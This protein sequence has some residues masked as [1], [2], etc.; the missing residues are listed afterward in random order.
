M[1]G[2]TVPL[3]TE[4]ILEDH[5]T[6]SGVK[7]PSSAHLEFHPPRTTCGLLDHGKR[8]YHRG[9]DF[10]VVFTTT[11]ET[12]PVTGATPLPKFTTTQFHVDGLG[13]LNRC[14]VHPYPP[15]LPITPFPEIEFHKFNGS[16]PHLWFKRCETYFDVYQTDP[17]LWVHLAT[18]RLVDSAALW[19]QTMQDTI[20]KMN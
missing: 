11:L 4:S 15:Y 1:I 9:A 14:F 10:G 18:M 3:L 20:S 7:A 12:A 13:H 19:F 2:I 17:S 6:S 5:F 8:S 16:I